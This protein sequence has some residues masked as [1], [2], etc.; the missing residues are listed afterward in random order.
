MS[1]TYKHQLIHCGVIACVE[2]FYSEIEELASECR[3]VVDNATG[4][5]AETQR[6]QTLG[7]TADTLE[8]IQ[9]NE[10]ISSLLSDKECEEL[11]QVGIMIKVKSK[12]TPPSRDVRASNAISHATAAVEWLTAWYENLEEQYPDEDDESELKASIEAV[13]EFVSTLEDHISEV[14]GAEFPGMFG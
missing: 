8:N 2:H 5:L 12:R 14:E 3:E 13:K 1:T 6:V 11:I 4:G 10:D 7:E 9:N